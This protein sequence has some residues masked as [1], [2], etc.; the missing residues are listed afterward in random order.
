[1]DFQ[2]SCFVADLR[3]SLGLELND[4]N[5]PIRPAENGGA[6]QPFH[7]RNRTAIDYFKRD[8]IDESIVGKGF[9]ERHRFDEIRQRD[10][11]VGIEGSQA[12]QFQRGL[13]DDT[14]GPLGPDEKSDQV[15]TGRVLLEPPADGRHLSLRGDYFQR[16]DLVRGHAILDRAIAAG[17]GGDVA[18]EHAVVVRARVASVKQPLSARGCLQCQ[19]LHPGLHL[20][21]AGASV[22]S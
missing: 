1:M 15:V 12:T 18:A 20:G 4:E 2:A 17:V 6:A 9:H 16:Q 11:V 10:D 7:S 19:C 3:F 5:V 14:Q 13:R 21:V 22:D 8:R